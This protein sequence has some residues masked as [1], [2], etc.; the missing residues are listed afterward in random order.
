MIDDKFRDAFLDFLYPAGPG[1]PADERYFHDD[2]PQ[3]TDSTRRRSASH[4]AAAVAA[5]RLA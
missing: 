3:M 4:E 2:I 5:R 1:L